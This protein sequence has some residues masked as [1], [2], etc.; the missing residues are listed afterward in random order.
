M[1]SYKCNTKDCQGRI[2]FDDVAAASAE[3]KP[4]QQ[5]FDFRVVILDNTP[6]E[7]PRCHQS[8]YRYELEPA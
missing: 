4:P 5:R 6:E 2:E 8:Y 3:A 7:C 1:A